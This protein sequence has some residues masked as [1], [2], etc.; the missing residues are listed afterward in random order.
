MP[1]PGGFFIASSFEEDQGPLIEF[2]RVTSSTKIELQGGA[3]G[4]DVLRCRDGVVLPQVVAFKN[5][6]PAQRHFGSC[7]KAEAVKLVKSPVIEPRL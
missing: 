3:H 6:I 5:E 7:R 4:I 1:S 2:L